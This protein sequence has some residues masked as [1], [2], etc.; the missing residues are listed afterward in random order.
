MEK[1]VKTAEG[2][3]KEA[4]KILWEAVKKHT[5]N[6]ALVIGLRGDLGA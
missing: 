4:A 5:E 1:I 3:E 6:A 2:M